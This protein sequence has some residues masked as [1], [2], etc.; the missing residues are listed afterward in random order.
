MNKDVLY[1]E[2]DDDITNIIEKIKNTKEKIVAIIPPKKDTVFRSAVNLRLIAKLVSGEKRVAVLITT[3]A[4]L[5]KIALGNGIP[6]ANTLK[7]RPII[8]GSESAETESSVKSTSTKKA[9]SEPELVAT[10]PKKTTKPSTVALELDES[11]DNFDTDEIE[12]VDNPAK[13]LP[14]LK[15]FQKIAVFGAVVLV[16]LIGATVWAT[17]FAPGASV[18]VVVRTTADNFSESA[19][20]TTKAS[21]DD[22]KN[23]IFLLE[24]Q[25]IVKTSSVKFKAT[26]QR[27]VGK[28]ASGTIIVST[29][30][31]PSQVAAE[32][33]ITIKAGTKFTYDQKDY[34]ADKD[35]VISVKKEDVTNNKCDNAASFFNPVCTK[36][37]EV[38]ISAVDP[39]EKYNID[40][41][42]S[43][44]S[45]SGSGFRIKGN[46]KSISGGTDKIVTSVQDSDVKKAKEMLA[47]TNETEGKKELM[48]GISKGMIVIDSTFKVSSK[49]PVSNPKVGEEVKDDEQAELKAEAIFTVYAVDKVHIEDFVKAK[50]SGKIADDQKVYS[51]G[52]PFI[53]RFTPDES[54][55]FHSIAK[56]KTTT[57]I[58]P[59]ITEQD[60][61]DKVRGRKVG[62]IQSLIKSINGVSTV[63]INT[64]VFWVRSIPDDPNKV[65]VELKVEK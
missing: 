51:V 63:D 28:K 50:T 29:D 39:G 21:E 31:S 35:T 32:H 52:A 34:T 25:K 26:G 15:K 20:F 60:I 58:G 59:K 33:G 40:S 2:P 48:D 54:K 23:G 43:G 19:S 56:I 6:V 22:Y 4:S 42:T 41:H 9:E 3:D 47:S 55:K 49:D 46:K 7:S 5:Q 11:D 13:K 57:E 64:S 27:N 16:I 10:V 38:S 17:Q 65:K 18:S 44:W 8:P 24:E 61:M 45:T 62:E 30:Y 53:E 37:A 1:I 36:S 12:P 14:N